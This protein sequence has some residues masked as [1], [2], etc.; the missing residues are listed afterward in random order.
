MKY[1]IAGLV[2]ANLAGPYV[3]LVL[4]QLLSFISQQR[5]LAGLA[6]SPSFDPLA[7]VMFGSIGLIT[8][9][10]PILFVS[11]ICAALMGYF[12]LKS[13]K[14]SAICGALIGFLFVC[15]LLTR[16]LKYFPDLSLLQFGTLAVY[17]APDLLAGALTGIICGWIYWRIATGRTA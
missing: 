6:L 11:S 10:P 16:A 7:I 15:F 4:S 12:E 13:R 14:A 8:Y 9:G 1:A 17:G 5:S 2:A 3:L